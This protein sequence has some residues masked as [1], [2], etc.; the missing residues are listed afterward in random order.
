[1]K[2]VTAVAAIAVALA[3]CA[4]QPIVA[5]L[6]RLG[7]VELAPY[8]AYEDCADLVAGDRLDYRFES[9]EPVKFTIYYRDGGAR[10]APINRDGTLS[11]SGVL[12]ARIA[13]RYCLS[14]EADASGSL[15]NYRANVRIAS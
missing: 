7:Y 15:V 2:G 8:E 1:M 11:E 12:A 3:A 9:T 5:G 13:A 4:R 10:V 6:P 14:W